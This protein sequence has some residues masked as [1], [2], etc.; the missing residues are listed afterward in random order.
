[1]LH[2]SATEDGHG[3]ETLLIAN[4]GTAHEVVFGD[5]SPRKRQHMFGIYDAHFHR[6]CLLLCR[7]NRQVFFGLLFNLCHTTLTAN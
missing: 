3:L 1:M 7:D 6:A 4:P 2:E 5:M